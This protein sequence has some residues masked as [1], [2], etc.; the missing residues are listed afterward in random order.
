[1]IAKRAAQQPHSRMF[2]LVTTDDKVDRS[3]VRS[4]IPA[5]AP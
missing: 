3:T 5:R 2:C 1:V 4:H